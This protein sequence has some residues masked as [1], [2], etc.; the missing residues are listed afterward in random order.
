MA[1]KPKNTY[2][3]G[4]YLQLLYR[5]LSGAAKSKQ[6]FVKDFFDIILD[7]YELEEFESKSEVQ[8]PIGKTAIQ[9]GVWKGANE[10]DLNKIFNGNRPCK[11]S[12]E[13]AEHW[14]AKWQKSSKLFL[15]TKRKEKTHEPA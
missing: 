4:P 10:T 11:C 7:T 1:E 3:L 2:A 15:L 8:R 14:T 6:G 5:H 13:Y 9:A 12:N